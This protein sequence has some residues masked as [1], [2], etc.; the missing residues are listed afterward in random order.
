MAPPPTDDTP[1]RP[2]QRLTARC[3]E[4]VDVAR[5]A[6]R[7][8]RPWPSDPGERH[9]LLRALG[10]AARAHLG[11]PLWVSLANHYDPAL[12]PAD[13][14]RRVL[15]AEALALR[16]EVLAAAYRE[17]A[18]VEA[19]GRPTVAAW[20]AR[21]GL[22]EARLRAIRAEC[23]ATRALPTRG[24]GPRRADPRGDTATRDTPDP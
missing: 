10:D 8:G 15:A 4:A 20:A 7:G 5:E 9:T 19:E 1:T 3:R 2:P 23:P 12:D 18:G 22:S 11:A 21:V 14:T 17:A 16:T 6:A 13:P 24:S